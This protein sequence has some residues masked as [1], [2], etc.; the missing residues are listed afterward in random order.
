[1]AKSLESAS[2]QLLGLSWKTAGVYSHIKR[3]SISI[4]AITPCANV[5][6]LFILVAVP[7]MYARTRL[8]QNTTN[9]MELC[10]KCK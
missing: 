10:D 7:A 5:Y 8:H 6:C 1:M 3:K 9:I 4:P 2:N